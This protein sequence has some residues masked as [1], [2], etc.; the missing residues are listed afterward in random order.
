V[1]TGQ[2]DIDSIQVIRSTPEP[3]LRLSITLNSDQLD[4]IDGSINND[5]LLL[6]CFEASEHCNVTS[7]CEGKQLPSAQVINFPPCSAVNVDPPS[8]KCIKA[9]DEATTSTADCSATTLS[10][11]SPNSSLETLFMTPKSECQEEPNF[12]V[13]NPVFSPEAITSD[14]CEHTPAPK[15]PDTQNRLDNIKQL[16]LQPIHNSETYDPLEPSLDRKMHFATANYYETTT[17]TS[18]TK[19]VEL[20]VADQQVIEVTDE[21][22]K[23]LTSAQSLVSTTQEAPIVTENDSQQN[24]SLVSFEGISPNPA[25]DPATPLIEIPSPSNNEFFVE[26]PVEQAIFLMPSN[27]QKQTAYASIATVVV[28]PEPY[29][30]IDPG[31]LPRLAS[32]D[33]SEPTSFR[34]YIPHSNGHSNRI[35]PITRKVSARL[36]KHSATLTDHNPTKSVVTFAPSISSD[37]S[38]FRVIQCKNLNSGLHFLS[39]SKNTKPH[40]LNEQVRGTSRTTTQGDLSSIIGSNVRGNSAG[41]IVRVYD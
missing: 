35:T 18:E 41:C 1:D 3:I 11:E 23:M 32:G 40:N 16:T 27:N 38:R 9:L 19:G 36:N 26:E 24:D 30:R 28:Q 33:F 2:S 10:K 34:A 25:I 17:V 22:R 39:S 14:C 12:L 4:E 8:F 21:L 31:S 13:I 7:N 15:A 6:P 37:K 29:W 5:K 20:D